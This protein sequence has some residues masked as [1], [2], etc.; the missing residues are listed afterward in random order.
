MREEIVECSARLVANRV[1]HKLRAAEI[2]ASSAGCGSEPMRITRHELGGAELGELAARLRS[3]VPATED[4]SAVVAEILARVRSGG[5]AALREI[6][7]ELGEE[8]GEELPS[9]R[10]RSRSRRPCSRP[11][12]ARPAVAAAN[13]GEVAAA[14]L[15]ARWRRSTSCSSRASA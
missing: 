9:T 12:C 7:T 13:I 3:M 15:E 4:V 6:A 1:S 8:P 14:E 11:T 10:R 5:D 2:D